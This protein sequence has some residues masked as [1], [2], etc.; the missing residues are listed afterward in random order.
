MDHAELLRRLTINDA[1]LDDGRALPPAALPPGTLALVRLAALV[2]VSGGG[3]SLGVE[4]EAALGA[5]VAAHEIVDVLTAAVPV[6]G[7]PRAVSAAP[8][9]ALAL[10]LEPVEGWT[11][12]T[13]DG[14]GEF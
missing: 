2:G 9:V 13:R 5:G 11:D 4:V 8:W 6:V 1:R 12:P 7:L 3:P 10:G 14:V